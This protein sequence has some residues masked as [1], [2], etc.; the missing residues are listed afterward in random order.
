MSRRTR[1]LGLA[2]VV[3]SF[4]IGA[5]AV[6]AGAAVN[7]VTPDDPGA[8]NLANS[9]AADPSQVTGAHFDSTTPELPSE[10]GGADSG[11]AATGTPSLGGFPTAGGD[12]GIMTSGDPKLAD[13]PNND[14]GSGRSN[15]GPN[16]RGD[17]DFDVL[18]LRMSVNVPAGANCLA[19]DYR[20][21]SEEFPE[22]VGSSFNDAFI[23]EVDTS[24]WTTNQSDVSSPNDF[25]TQ[26]S[27]GGVSINSV[28]PTA[29]SADQA[30]GTTY[31]GA[32]ALVTTKTQ[33]APGGHNVYLSIFDQ[34]DDILDSAVFVDNLRFINES[35]ET[36]VPPNLKPVFTSPPTISG[37]P[38]N[39][40]TLT[41][42]SGNATNSPTTSTFQ[43]LRD[44][45]PI[46]GAFAS[47]KAKKSATS[48]SY[49]LTTADIG[50][51]ISVTQT[52][53]N[54]QG[55]ASATSS[56]TAPVVPSPGPCSNVFVGTAAA[57]TLTGTVGGD[58]INGL[59]G[60]DIINGAG[61]N[62]C[63]TGD[64]GN[65]TLSGDLGNDSLSGGAGNDRLSG[66]TGIDR[67]SGGRGKDRLSGGAG[68]DTLTG[69]A[70]VD[71]ITGGKGK[72]RYSAG[73]G[74][75]VVTSKNRKK[76]RVNCGKGKKDR[77]RA[78]RNDRLRGCE[79]VR[80]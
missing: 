25:A 72:N 40:N 71:R 65:D 19:L 10:V 29:V 53:S 67:L 32:T 57:N 17:T 28:G 45:V 24:N 11:P 54:A 49:Q 20:F 47:V 23:A 33:I 50:H 66:G 46:P 6:P 21:L 31:D 73:A 64:L 27:T 12:F 18:I 62:D 36:C 4:A 79:I 69:G 70:G 60:N 59:A 43:W 48:A 58:Q 2:A 26:T 63:L 77:V 39:N 34:G 51:T 75:D 78:D 55:T 42:T 16:V 56:A 76:E 5:F 13:Q 8:L 22:F 9:I 37:A 74:N 61:G 14:G 30:S 52:V 7:P 1:R 15:G 44:G 80:R 3:T 38:V 41:A 68:N 35:P